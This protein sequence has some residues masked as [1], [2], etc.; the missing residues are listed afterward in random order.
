MQVRNNSKQ[1]HNKRKWLDTCVHKRFR[2]EQ[3]CPWILSCKS[4]QICLWNARRIVSKLCFLYWDRV[5]T[6]YRVHTKNRISQ[7]QQSTRRQES[8][9]VSSYLSLQL[10]LITTATK[11]K[12]TTTME[13]ARHLW[14]PTSSVLYIPR[15]T[16]EDLKLK[17]S[18]RF[19][20]EPSLGVNTSSN[21]P[22]LSTTTSV[23]LYWSPWACRPITI[24]FV[25]PQ[26]EHI[27]K[28]NVTRHKVLIQVNQRLPGTRRGM[29]RQMIGSRNTVPPKIFRMVPFGLSHIFFKL[30]STFVL[31]ICQPQKQWFL[32]FW[33]KCC[34]LSFEREKLPLTRA[35]SGVIVA[36]LIPTLYFCMA[37]A[38]SMVT[39]SSVLSLFSIPR[40]KYTIWISK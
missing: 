19:G 40:S 31:F 7:I 15:A 22:G 27:H 12:T 8:E 36:H 28:Q 25:Q 17:T 32:S 20:A 2:L 10:I 3:I 9:K 14:F 1:T 6:F 13:R 5:A 18:K 23:A 30:N 24:G 16:P 39:W 21:F 4:L 37:F 38:A 34:C 26:H 29:L 11:T 35:S 33:K